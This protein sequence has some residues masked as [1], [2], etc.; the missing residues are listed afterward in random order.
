[1]ASFNGDDT[2]QG[3]SSPTERLARL[4]QAVRLDGVMRLRDAA[5]LLGVSEMT[6]RRDLKHPLSPFAYLGGYIVAAPDTETP[7]SIDTEKDVH[8]RAK[9]KAC[10][11]ALSLVRPDETIFI[12][13]GTTLPHLA[14]GLSQ[15]MPL[16]VV[17]YA[18]NI[19]ERLAGRPSIRLILLGGVYEPASA[20]FAAGPQLALLDQLGVTK[21]FISAGGLHPERGATCSN[22]HEVPVKQKALAVALETHL[23]IDRS[24]EGLVRP[25]WFAPADAFTSIIS[26]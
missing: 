4:A 12:D 3:R 9:A 19:A 22:F 16:T 5:A 15:G 21:A 10:A 8:A 11:K 1:M 25:A 24:K 23:V 13:C 18:L 7:Y 2:R 14:V 26:A 20:S 6:V 17:T